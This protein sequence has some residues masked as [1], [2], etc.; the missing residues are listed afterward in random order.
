M[1]GEQNSEFMADPYSAAAV[2]ASAA[3]P[4]APPPSLPSGWAATPDL[5]GSSDSTPDYLF[6]TDFDESFRRSWGERLTFHT[7]GAYLVGTRQRSRACEKKSAALFFCA[8]INL[9]RYREWC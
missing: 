9:I 2:N 8:S 3:G 4:R 7:G 1:S 5:G 6:E